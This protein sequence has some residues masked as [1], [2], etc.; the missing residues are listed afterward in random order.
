[1]SIDYWTF[2]V[3]GFGILVISN[4]GKG[5][6]DFSKHHPFMLYWSGLGWSYN[7]Y[8]RRHFLC[9]E[10]YFLFFWDKTE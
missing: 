10:L 1:M 4:F 8:R 7:I 5:F 2:W 9:T 6:R 3:L